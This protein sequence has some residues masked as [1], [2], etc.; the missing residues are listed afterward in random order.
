[1]DQIME[2]QEKKQHELKRL[3]KTELDMLKELKLNVS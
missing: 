1:M 2:K 3:K